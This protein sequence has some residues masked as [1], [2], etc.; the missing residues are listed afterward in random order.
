MHTRKRS[1]VP[2]KDKKPPK[3]KKV[4]S[5]CGKELSL[6]QGFYKTNSRFSN[7]GR[8]DICKKCMLDKIDMRD[9][10]SIY[11]I[12]KTLDFPFLAKYWEICLEK[13]NPFGT[14]IRMASSGMNE[15]KNTTWGDS[16]F[17]TDE[18][19]KLEH[20]R[21]M[22][23]YK[24]TDDIIEFFGAGYSS[25]EYDAM[26]RKYNFLK[27]N[28]PEKTNMHVEALKT[29]VRYKVKEEFA[30]AKGNV[31]EAKNWASMAK[32]AA[33]SAKINPSQ[34]S[35]SDLSDGLDGFAQLTLAV[36]KAVDVIDIL[37]RFKQKPQDMIDFNI[38]CNINYI[39]NLQGLP[40][41]EYK[42]VYAFYDKMK[43]QYADRYTFLKDD[44]T[45]DGRKSVESFIE[46][47]ENNDLD[48]N[49]Y[50]DELENEVS[51]DGIL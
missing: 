4:C 10:D 27:N 29:Y 37:P 16:V 8:S 39:R 33:T 9:I 45:P 2:P 21:R 22:K 13:E 3:G 31:G 18:D 1:V 51:E 36:E 7:D 11:D 44:T 34:L 20:L 17:E 19:V 28:Y 35:A 43:E 6:E 42:D 48:D 49:P 46:T 14:Y 15:F 24:I 30:T 32:D 38:W 40:I 41:C 47:E 26:W 25:E 5:Q 50:D 12:L 23:V